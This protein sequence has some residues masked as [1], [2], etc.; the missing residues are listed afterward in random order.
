M[1]DGLSSVIVELVGIDEEV[2]AEK[3]GQAEA[4]EETFGIDEG[5][6]RQHEGGENPE[7]LKQVAVGDVTD[8]LAAGALCLGRVGQATCNGG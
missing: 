1:I 7:P 6:R 8:K 3:A 4:E 5:L 2:P